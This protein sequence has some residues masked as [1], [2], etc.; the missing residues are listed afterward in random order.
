MMLA[1]VGAVVVLLI[2]SINYLSLQKVVIR[3]V[4]AIAAE[5]FHGAS[6][7]SDSSIQLASAAQ[8]Q[9]EGANEQAS[10]L[11][12]TSASL[13]EIAFQTNLLA[14]NAAVE[15][16]RAGEAGKGFAV[17]AEEVRN[18]AQRSAKAAELEAM[19]GVR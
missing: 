10:T 6:Q 17:V 11:E 4:K 15:A 12:E 14:L 18:L 8:S 19:V 3:P 13:E 2:I 5:L 9:A 1:G 16:A 7:V